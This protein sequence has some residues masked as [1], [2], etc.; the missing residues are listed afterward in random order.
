MHTE[1]SDIFNGKNRNT[2][3]DISKNYDKS[4]GISPYLE[5]LSEES[6]KSVF[7]SELNGQDHCFVKK[8]NYQ[9]YVTKKT[10]Y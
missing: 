4:F 3:E 5:P 9:F 2:Y 8:S 6:F 10:H 7:F 1:V